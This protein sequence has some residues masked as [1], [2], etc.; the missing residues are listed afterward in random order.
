MSPPGQRPSRRQAAQTIL[1]ALQESIQGENRP[2]P[3]GKDVNDTLC[4]RLGLA[5]QQ[6]VKGWER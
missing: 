5:R 4:H 3:F 1:S 2:P 6:A